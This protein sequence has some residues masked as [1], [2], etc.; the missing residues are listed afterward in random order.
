MELEFEKNFWGNCV[1]TFDEEQ[2]HFVYAEKMGLGRNHYSFLVPGGATKIIDVGG[3]P[4]SMLLKTKGDLLGSIVVDPLAENYPDWVHARYDCRGITCIKGTGEGLSN[5]TAQYDEA[6]MYNV[7]QHTEDP[8]RIV[9][10]L[11]Q[12]A[13]KVRI[14]EWIDIPPHEGH[15][16]MLTE[17]MLNDAIGAKGTTGY[18]DGKNGCLGK[19][20]AFFSN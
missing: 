9:H 16:H 12:V 17:A 3:G 18:L 4:T 5:L 11:K 19:Y 6:W 8:V 10:N 15:P 7:L 13:K 2:K 20:W 1:N 14:F